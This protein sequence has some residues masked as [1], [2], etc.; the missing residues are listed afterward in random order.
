MLFRGSSIRMGR[1]KLSKR[2]V[3]VA[4]PDAVKRVV[5]VLLPAPS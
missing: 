4:G 3:S 1:L 5:V 2:V